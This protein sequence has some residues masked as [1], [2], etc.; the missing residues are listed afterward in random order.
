MGACVF[1]VGYVRQFEE[2]VDYDYYYYYWHFVFVIRSDEEEWKFL[3]SDKSPSTKFDGAHGCKTA[4]IK[5][6]TTHSLR[7]R[8]YV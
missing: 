3:L 1:I 8:T 2:R 5:K 4:S 6:I 7:A